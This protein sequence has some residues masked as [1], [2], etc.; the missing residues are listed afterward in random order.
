MPSQHTV[1]N[2]Y[3]PMQTS[4]EVGHLAWR[5]DSGK[6]RRASRICCCF[7]ASWVLY[8][9]ESKLVERWDATVFSAIF[10]TAFWAPYQAAFSNHEQLEYDTRFWVDRVFDT[11]FMLDMVL[12]FFL[13]FP[14]ERHGAIRWIK[15]TNRIAKNYLTGWFLVDIVCVVPADVIFFFFST[16]STQGVESTHGSITMIGLHSMRILRLFRLVRLFRILRLSRILV[17]WHCKIGVQYAHLSLAKF[18]FLVIVACHWISCLWGTLAQAGDM[19]REFGLGDGTTWLIVH[20]GKVKEEFMLAGD[21][22]VPE[23]IFNKDG[24]I[25]CISLYWALAT[26]TSIG[27]GDIVPTNIPEYVVC[28]GVMAAGSAIWAYVIGGICGVLS[29]MDPHTMHFKQ[30]MDDL[31][32]M[33]NFYDLPQDM[34]RRV[35]MYVHESRNIK[36]RTAGQV[37]KTDLSPT[38]RGEVE[39][40]CNTEW[41][42]KVFYLK[43][44]PSEVVAEVAQ[45]LEARLFAPGELV[46]STRDEREPCLYIV[47]RGVVAKQG[48]VY[49]R[50]AVF[51]EDMILHTFELRDTSMARAMS[52]VEVYLLKRSALEHIRYEYPE[53]CQK[54]RTAQVRMAV[55][56]KFIMEAQE[57]VKRRV[58]SQASFGEFESKKLTMESLLMAGHTRKSRKGLTEH[59]AKSLMGNE[60]DMAVLKRLDRMEEFLDTR[61]S[62]LEKRMTSVEE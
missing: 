16:G 35:R 8:P 12:Q 3:P 32:A 62:Q 9:A 47:Q 36:Q 13:A 34:R 7:P 4:H 44:L 48:R 53:E 17:R 50:G 22:N 6:K 27:Y 11:I 42:D 57:H 59:S 24:E 41:M 33:M 23:G 51:G 5:N 1:T 2:G 25:F 14:E 38:L 54:I 26:L 39:V 61:F 60:S 31:N 29:S 28:I 20:Q 37:L 55:R 10:C 30:N 46:G 45:C 52:F 49:G 18:C 40:V 43:G 58:Q 56:R 21:E 19:F 15:D